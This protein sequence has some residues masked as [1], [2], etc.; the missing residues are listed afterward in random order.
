MYACV[1]TGFKY[2][3]LMS[4]T[5]K[6]FFFLY[7][8]FFIDGNERNGVKFYNLLRAEFK[9][10]FRIEMIKKKVLTLALNSTM[11]QVIVK[12]RSI[13]RINKYKKAR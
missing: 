12:R 7:I 9:A 1:K 5:I 8:L 13:S 3:K 6:K 11:Q 2:P 4:L 10:S